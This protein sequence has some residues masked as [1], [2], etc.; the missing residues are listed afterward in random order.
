MKLL[1][2]LFAAAAIATA[3]TGALADPVFS[4]VGGTTANY[5]AVDYDPLP[6]AEFGATFVKTGTLMMSEAG[7]VTFSFVS[8]SATYNNSFEAFYIGGTKIW[9]SDNA[10]K[11]FTVNVGAGALNF[12]YLSQG[13]GTPVGNGAVGMGVDLSDTNAASALI[14]FND[15]ATIDGDYDDLTISAVAAVPEAETYA[16]LLAGLGL[17]GTIARRRNKAKAA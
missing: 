10:S 5:S 12:A 3:A 14:V 1:K 8:S 17:M 4:I 13:V 15:S 7:Q 9:S 6:M 16:M 2:S 11:T